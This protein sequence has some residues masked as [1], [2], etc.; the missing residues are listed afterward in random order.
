MKNN[1]IYSNINNLE[2]TEKFAL[3]RIIEKRFPKIER[4]IDGSCT[5]KISVKSSMKGK[6]KNLKGKRFIISYFLESPKHKFIS[7]SRDQG[8]TA[9]FDIAKAAHKEMNN[10]FNEVNKVLRPEEVGWKKYSLKKLFDKYN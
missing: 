2:D 8:D 10:L 5:L 7:K 1:I 9:D 4:M 3:E 6:G